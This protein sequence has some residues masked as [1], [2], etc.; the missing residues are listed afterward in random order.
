MNKSL[1][2]LAALALATTAAI[3]TPACDNPKEA[4][5]A[6]QVA[7]AES[8]QTALGS[9]S[10][11]HRILQGLRGINP[12]WKDDY[13]DKPFDRECRSEE[14]RAGQYNAK[15]EIHSAIKVEIGLEALTIDRITC[16]SLDKVDAEYLRYRPISALH[17]LR[18]YD[19]FKPMAVL[20]NVK[21]V[22]D[23]TFGFDGAFLKKMDEKYKGKLISAAMMQEITDEFDRYEK[24]KAVKIEE[25]LKI[26]DDKFHGIFDGRKEYAHQ[27]LVFPGARLRYSENKYAVWSETSFEKF[28]DKDTLTRMRELGIKLRL[29]MTISDPEGDGSWIMSVTPVVKLLDVVRGENSTAATLSSCIGKPIS[30]K[31]IE[32][33]ERAAAVNISRFIMGYSK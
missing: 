26:S 27:T 19:Q 15:T 13:Y 31:G 25:A 6:S 16:I 8:V 10:I 33:V 28:I 18:D 12:R 21:E 23:N 2:S 30:E 9:K 1:H 20:G 11:N 32:E 3:T 17:G 7:T 29:E 5:T 4:I 22:Y 14:L 24:E